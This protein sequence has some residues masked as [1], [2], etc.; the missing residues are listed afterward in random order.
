MARIKYRTLV[1]KPVHPGVKVRTEREQ[2][3]ISRERLSDAAGVDEQLLEYFELGLRHPG[4][5]WVQH[6]EQHLAILLRQE[7]APA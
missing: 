5:H 6:V 1:K 3:G 4:D 7:G 2:V